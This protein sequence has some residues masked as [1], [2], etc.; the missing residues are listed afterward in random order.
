MDFG[1]Y[2]ALSLSLENRNIR[3]A[4]GL[5]QGYHVI[6][7]LIFYK[8]PISFHA[9]QSSF[10]GPKGLCPSGIKS[11][12]ICVRQSNDEGS[13]STMDEIYRFRSRV[14]CLWVVLKEIFFG[15]R[16]DYLS[17]QCNHKYNHPRW[18]KTGFSWWW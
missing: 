9:N 1:E 7:P 10:F 2:E 4:L 11:W 3:S 6:P 17:Y 16:E 18:S 8:K 15:S 14:V 5:W 13:N 12:W